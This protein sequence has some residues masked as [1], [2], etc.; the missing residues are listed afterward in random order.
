MESTKY[1]IL[2]HSRFRM[3]L[4]YCVAIGLFYI[5]FNIPLNFGFYPLNENAAFDQGFGTVMDSIFVVNVIT[6]FNTA[7]YNAQ[8]LTYVRNRKKIV[9]NYLKV[10]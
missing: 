10:G 7:Y 5:A 8:T 9:A 3:Y 4:D 1:V 2:P 6:N